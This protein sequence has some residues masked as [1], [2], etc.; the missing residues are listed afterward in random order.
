M[1]HALTTMAGILLPGVPL[2]AFPWAALR[3]QHPQAL[4]CGQGL[5]ARCKGKVPFS[6]QPPI[7]RS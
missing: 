4:P 1:R 5:G 6:F 2:E 3:F 7:G